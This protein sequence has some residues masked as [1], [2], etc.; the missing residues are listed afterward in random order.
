MVGGV[1]WEIEGSAPK[2]GLEEFEGKDYD[3][4]D[5]QVWPS[6]MARGRR[7]PGWY[8]IGLVGPGDELQ[9]RNFSLNVWK[10]V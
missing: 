6:L 8:S 10:D 1:A 2:R 7:H 3:E 9:D 4:W 5:F